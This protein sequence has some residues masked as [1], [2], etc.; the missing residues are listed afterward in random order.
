MTTTFHIGCAGWSI[1]KIYS[2]DF[3]SD[4]SHLQR[5]S[6]QL[7]A[8]EINSS[9][10]RPHRP[11]TY[12]R[13][14]ETVPTNFRFSV[15]MPRSI[16]HDARLVAAG[17]PLDRFFDEI[18]ALEQKLGCVLIQLPPSLNFDRSVVR[19]FLKALRHRFD[20]SCVVEPRHATWFDESANEVLAEFDIGRVAAD[21]SVVQAAARPGGA[22]KL[23]Y[24][25]LHGSPKIY[26]SEYEH[27]CLKML[28]G[29]LRKAGK[30]ARD[31]W[32]IFDNTALGFA[33]GNAL[34]VVKSL[35]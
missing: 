34:E 6:A 17:K 7:N 10:Y 25:R 5:Y 31:V 8:V 18:S 30:N 3:P 13:W 4:G 20:G 29:Q 27:D 26:Y 21:P 11:S 12:A 15:K 9:F 14:S 23:I 24:Y 32:C 1:P 33:T 19:R 2:G 28:T 16:T 22:G 35:R